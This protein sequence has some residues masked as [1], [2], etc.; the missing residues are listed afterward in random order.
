MARGKTSGASQ[1]QLRVGE[2]IR[3]ALSTALARGDTHDPDLAH[4]SVTVSEVRMSP[5]LKIATAFVLPLGGVNTEV[6]IK[7]LARN[8]AE[9]RHLVTK[10]VN[11]KF[12]PD[13]RFLADTTFDEM[14][15]TRAM[16]ES[17]A[18]KRDLD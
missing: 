15:K 2:V 5:D 10:D 11:L 4:V 1:R 7:A 13:L 14:D 6:V 8:K 17:D 18:V 12:S 16:L 3:H 9:L